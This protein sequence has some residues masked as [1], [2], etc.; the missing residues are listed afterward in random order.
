MGMCSH[1]ESDKII[2]LI[3]SLGENGSDLCECLLKM[4][5]PQITY[6]DFNSVLPTP[7]HPA[8]AF[9]GTEFL[10]IAFLLPQDGSIKP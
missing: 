5:V 2:M 1:M 9:L 10:L 6:C 4:D 3:P 7:R 8:A